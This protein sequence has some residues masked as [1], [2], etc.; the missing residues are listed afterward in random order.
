MATIF[1]DGFD[2]YGP[3]GQFSPAVT[4]LI[5]AG[6]WTYLGLLGGS[7]SI[8]PP[9]NAVEQGYAL[10]IT[11]V[12]AFATTVNKTF[13]TSYSRWIGGFRFS[14]PL[15]GGSVG[16]SASNP[17]TGLWTITINSGTGIISF[18]NPST[19]LDNGGVVTQNSIHYL[20]FD[21]TIGSNAPYQVW[22]DGTSIMSGTGNT[23]SSNASIFQFF[24]GNYGGYIT[25]DDFYL[26]DDT[27][28]V[29]NAV[30]LSSPRIQTQYPIS[31][32]QKQFTSSGSIIGANTTATGNASAPNANTLFLRAYT[33]GANMTLNS[34]ACVPMATAQS[35]NFKA[36]VYS[37]NAGNAGTLLSSGTQ[38]TGASNGSTLVGPL[39][40][41]Q[42]L[43]A[44]TQ[45][46]IG[47]ITDSAVALSEQNTAA[48]GFVASN[49]Y[50]AGAPGTAP[51]MT[52]FQP[53]WLL[54]GNCTGS[55]SNWVSLTNNP[56]PGDVSFVSSDTV[57]NEDLYGFQALTVTPSAI[58]TMMV[59]SNA[60]VD[61]TGTVTID[62]QTKSGA[63]DSAGSTANQTP[64]TSYQ[65]LDS[66]FETDP[67][68]GVAW[69]QAG[70][71]AAVSGIKIIT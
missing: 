32:S 2:K 27:G 3:A 52:G 4:N 71:N 15:S 10:Y 19:T 62:L 67:N 18:S 70:L 65:W 24:A 26:F 58:Y 54:W 7:V 57:G 11:Q 25:V 23:G 40:T 20:E 28:S 21:V 31:D 17:S 38:V 61:Y 69:T 35:A 5:T 46:W 50:S 30:L 64:G 48:L 16:C 55:A 36:V 33:P 56:P 6:E 53:S 12:S 60:R 63:T 1:I 43:T 49:T 42:A 29:N 37:N 44:A 22:L 34:V 14:A 51:S 66:I 59:K 47:F 13:P 39:V 8:A 41:P 45:Y 9:L 68:T